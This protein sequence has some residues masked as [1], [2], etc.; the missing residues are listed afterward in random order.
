MWKREVGGGG[1]GFSHG[2]YFEQQMGAAQ[3]V[4]RY[5]TLT[6]AENIIIAT[7]QEARTAF[8]CKPG[9]RN[10]IFSFFTRLSP[11]SILEM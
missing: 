5:T 2:V 3:S 9:F 8:G 7:F 1:Q 4:C 10:T 6:Q 11:L